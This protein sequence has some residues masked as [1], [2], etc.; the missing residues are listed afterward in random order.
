[1]PNEINHPLFPRTKTITLAPYEP[2]TLVVDV[3]ED[4]VAAPTVRI[5]RITMEALVFGEDDE[6]RPRERIHA[7][8]DEDTRPHDLAALAAKT[9]P[10]AERFEALARRYEAAHALLISDGVPPAHAAALGRLVRRRG[11]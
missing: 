7:F 6:T 1:M 9:R 8:S 2:D 11:A 10:G 3:D 4:P 5:P